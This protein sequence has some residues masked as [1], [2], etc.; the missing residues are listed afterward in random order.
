MQHAQF[1]S[2]FTLKKIEQK[3]G[4]RPS[5]GLTFVAKILWQ[6]AEATEAFVL[7][8][9]LSRCKSCCYCEMCHS[10]LFPSEFSELSEKL[11]KSEMPRSRLDAWTQTK[12]LTLSKS[13]PIIIYSF[14]LAQANLFFQGATCKMH[15]E[16]AM[17][18]YDLI[19][20]YEHKIT[21]W[22]ISRL[23]RPGGSLFSSIDW[24][25]FKSFRSFRSLFL[26]SFKP[27]I[28]N[29]FV[30]SAPSISLF[31]QIFQIFIILKS[32]NII[33]I[34]FKNPNFDKP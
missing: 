33:Q 24:T 15:L 30:S 17:T 2:N 34:H 3:C 18:F 23:E 4:C 31:P 20:K 7:S 19:S 27:Q 26:G 9:V 1:F 21:N 28:I 8:F 12:G 16:G 22:I 11:N 32:S 5:S 10:S 14:T 13:A 6:E 29:F 25:N